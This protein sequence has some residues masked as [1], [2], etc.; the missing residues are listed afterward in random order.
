MFILLGF[1]Y[2]ERFIGRWRLPR[3]HCSEFPSCKGENY[4]RANPTT[5][6]SGHLFTDNGNAGLLRI[7]FK[8]K[9]TRLVMLLIQ[10]HVCLRFLTQDFPKENQPLKL[11]GCCNVS[12]TRKQW[13]WVL[14]LKFEFEHLIFV[15]GKVPS[16]LPFFM[17][18]KL[19]VGKKEEDCKILPLLK[20]LLGS[21]CRS[22]NYIFDSVQ[23]ILVG[24][25][26]ACELID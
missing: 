21:K 25:R 4:H 17:L 10:V 13:K 26:L 20:I 12:L 23:V 2:Q 16:M 15:K 11:S 19:L 8:G 1:Q 18:Q 14:F 7:K 22:A 5:K 24:K 9:S 3:R 6:T